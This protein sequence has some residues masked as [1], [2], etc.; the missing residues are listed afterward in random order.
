MEIEYEDKIQF[1]IDH[2][3]DHLKAGFESTSAWHRALN[4]YKAKIE[5]NETEETTT[6]N[7][8]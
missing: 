4:D 7:N 1:L 2:F 3:E 5:T 6:K 8:S